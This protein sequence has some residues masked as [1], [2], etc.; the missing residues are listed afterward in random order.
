MCSFFNNSIE[1]YIEISLYSIASFL[2]LS[3]LIV[4]FD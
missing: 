4:R 3:G 2:S 1:I